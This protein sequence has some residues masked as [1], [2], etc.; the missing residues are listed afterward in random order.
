ML[1]FVCSF[2][3]FVVHS[4]FSC[5]FYVFTDHFTNKVNFFYFRWMK[6]SFYMVVSYFGRRPKFDVLEL[7]KVP[8]TWSSRILVADQNSMYSILSLG[9][10]SNAKVT[11]AKLFFC[12]LTL[13]QKNNF[14][15]VTFALLCEPQVRKFF[16]FTILFWT[17]AFARFSTTPPPP[18]GACALFEWPLLLSKILVELFGHIITLFTFLEMHFE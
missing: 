10:Q 7:K 14:A 15:S 13:E 2:L 12:S 9:S 11:D 18:S 16:W 17:H 4:I 3:L 5:S 6:C 1:H 8:S